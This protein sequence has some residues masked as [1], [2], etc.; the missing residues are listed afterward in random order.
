MY[1]ERSNSTLVLNSCSGLQTYKFRTLHIFVFLCLDIS[2]KY[3]SF[4]IVFHK[5]VMKEE[6]LI[7]VS[8]IAKK[9]QKAINVFHKSKMYSPLNYIIDDIERTMVAIASEGL[10]KNFINSSLVEKKSSSIASITLMCQ[11][12]ELSAFMELKIYKITSIQVLYD[13]CF[14]FE[15]QLSSLWQSILQHCHFLNVDFLYANYNIFFREL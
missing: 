1:Y 13:I 3:F 2:I 10:T 12:R 14:T 8:H 5:K 11:F 4:I 9:D 7:A 15:A 6:L